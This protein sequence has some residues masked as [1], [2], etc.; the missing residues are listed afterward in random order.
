MSARRTTPARL[1]LPLALALSGCGAELASELDEGQ[2]DEVVLALDEAGI[3]ARKEPSAAAAR[4]RFRVSVSRDELAPALGV[5]RDRQLPR[6]RPPGFAELFADRGLVPSASDERARYAA[7]TAG[8]LARSL[9]SIDGVDRARVHLGLVDRAAR[10]LD[11]PA[12]RARASVLLEHRPDLALDDGAVRA[13]VAG[14]VPE[15]SAEDVAVVRAPLRARRPHEPRLVTLGPIT[16]TR[17]TASA[18]KLLLGAS[19]A[20]HLAFALALALTQRRAS[21]ASE[22]E[23]RAPS[24]D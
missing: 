7:A 18:L 1:A 16:V 2:A 12:P 13:L 3:G 17:G 23:S 5:L 8:E 21:R 20:L 6:E 10:A 19:L 4:G 9:E 14:A 15:L 24:R 22:I 11:S